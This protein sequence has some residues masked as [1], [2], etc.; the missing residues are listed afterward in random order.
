M[1]L[2]KGVLVYGDLM[3]V[4]GCFWMFGGNVVFLV[5]YDLEIGK[6]MGSLLGNGLLKMNCGEEIGIFGNKYVVFGG[7]LWFLLIENVVNLGYFVVHVIGLGKNV[8]MG[9][10]LYWGKILLVWNDV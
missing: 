10:G 1:D 9:V 7:W 4:G 3:I 6:Y 5:F 8:G 2:C